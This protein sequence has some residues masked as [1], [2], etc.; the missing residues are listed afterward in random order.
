[1]R[2]ILIIVMTLAALP[3]LAQSGVWCCVPNR[4]FPPNLE[5]RP[6][7]QEHPPKLEDGGW[8]RT[9]C[10]GDNTRLCHREC[11]GPPD[12]QMCGWFKD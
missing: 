10:P 3:A 6:L 5:L 12:H 7:Y 11:R 2:S 8:T 4:T 9:Q 1:M